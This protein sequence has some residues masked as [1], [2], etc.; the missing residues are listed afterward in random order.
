MSFRAQGASLNSEMAQ[1]SPS[2]QPNP[3]D[4]AEA[5]ESILVAGLVWSMAGADRAPSE[6][7]DVLVGPA[8]GAALGV[9][10]SGKRSELLV[11]L[12]QSIA[13]SALFFLRTLDNRNRTWTRYPGCPLRWSAGRVLGNSRRWQLEGD[14]RKATA[15]CDPARLEDRVVALANGNPSVYAPMLLQSRPRF[16]ALDVDGS[17]AAS[18]LPALRQCWRR[19]HLVSVTKTDYDRL[20][21]EARAGSG[22][23]QR[24]GPV[25]VL[26]SGPDGVTI[27]AEGEARSLPAPTVR[28]AVQTDIGAGDVLLGI[29]TARLAECRSPISLDAAA[30]A[31]LAALPV[32]AR[33]LQSD[34]FI[35]FARAI[36][37]T[38]Q[39]AA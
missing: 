29:L 9:H 15:S 28:G 17:W 11:A 26:K 36:L 6:H 33:L 13:E 3:L 16:A 30:S 39:Q 20:P 37:K 38:E 7:D 27:S 31:Y 18:Q 25:L 35:D 2:F 4:G 22:L 19:V 34:R 14:P 8:V 1:A 5:D 24:G 23:G 10:T 12:P 21:S 32:L